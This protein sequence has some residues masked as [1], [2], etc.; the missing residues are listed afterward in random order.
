MLPTK[1]T[2]EPVRSHLGIQPRPPH[3]RLGWVS[4][5]PC[6]TLTPWP[7]KGTTSDSETVF[8]GPPGQN[9]LPRVTSYVSGPFWRRL[10]TSQGLVETS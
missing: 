1:G 8:Q 7:P 3:L 6:Q 10:G 4:S 9:T 2:E 5:W